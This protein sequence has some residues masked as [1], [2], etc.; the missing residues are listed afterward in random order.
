M[1]PDRLR[2]LGY[3]VER[4][5][6]GGATSGAWFATNRGGVPVVLKW[7][8]GDDA[9]RR[10]RALAPLIDELRT[11]G[12]PVPALLDVQRIDGGSLTAQQVLP[13]RSL[14]NPPP[15][16]IDELFEALDAQRGL[17]SALRPPDARPWGES[18]VH[19]LTDH[20]PGWASHD[21]LR[22]G[23]PQSVALLERICAIGGATE[24]TWFPDDGLVHL[25]LHTDN[26][27]VGEGGAL[28]G[29][30]DWDGACGGDPDF[31]RV[32]FAFDLDGHDQPIWERVEATD[33]DP[34]V[35]RAYI[36]HQALRCT[37][38]ALQVR[39]DDVPRQ[40]ARAERALDRYARDRT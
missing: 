24:A 2:D 1:N 28:T 13:G 19:V 8:P 29:I 26:V 3:H 14:D 6:P 10:A 37:A 4:R 27:L 18:V 7:V 34:R 23:G 12:S 40:L 20:Q 38:W 39:P 21:A 30:I 16:L 5:A 9:A 36:A 22:A 25:D 17:A 11:R 15:R 33:I 31:D 32:R 35:L